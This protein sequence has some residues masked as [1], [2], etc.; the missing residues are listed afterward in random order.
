[1]SSPANSSLRPAWKGGGRGFQPPPAVERQK[2][3][4][5][6]FAALNDEYDDDEDDSAELGKQAEEAANR[7]Q[8]SRRPGRSLADLAARAPQ[9]ER[10]ASHGSER[11][12]G[13]GSGGGGGVSRF[14]SYV[15]STTAP[16]SANVIRYTRERLLSMRPPPAP[17]APGELLK[18]IEGTVILSDVAQ[19]PVCWDTFDAEAIWAT[20]SRERR[21][22][23]KSGLPEAMEGGGGV[24][25]R[26]T[27]SRREAG[28]SSG[29]WQRGVAL[30]PPDQ[31]K[32]NRE[33]KDAENPSDLW[34]DPVAT[35]AAA[36]FSAF[37]AMPQ[38]DEPFDF[39][40]MAEATRKFDEDI[41]GSRSRT[42][43][44]ANSD[45]GVSEP[46]V[47]VDPKRPLASIGTTIQSGSGD[48][49]NVFED[50]DEPGSGD[51]EEGKPAIKGGEEDAS[52]SSRLMAMIG[53]K[54][55]TAPADAASEPAARAWGGAEPGSKENASVP[56]NPWG[57]P[58]LPSQ[59]AQGGGG[60]DIQARMR[61]EEMAQNAREAEVARRQQQE[62]EEV[63]R[64][65]AA[66][67]QSRNAA[68]LQQQ[69]Q[70]Q[71]Q[72]D[73]VQSQV[74]LVLMERISTILE[75]AWGQ[76][77]LV[78]ILS[79]LH[80]GDSRVIP[81]LSNTDALRALIL[82]NPRR[83]AL[84]PN[85]VFGTEMA[86]LLLTNA[87][88]LQ[89][90]TAQE[91]AKAAA[92]AQQQEIQRREEQR[93]MQERAA[94]QK[95]SVVSGA[96]WYYSD[97]Q[98]NVQGPFRGE[99]M[100][101]WL[102]AGYFKSDLPISQQQTGPFHPLSA[103]FPDLS[104]AFV[105][106]ELAAEEAQA[107]ERLDAERAEAEERQAKEAAERERQ[108]QETAERDHQAREA[109]EL[110]RQANEA[111]TRERTAQEVARRRAMEDAAAVEANEAANESSTQL[112]MML[113]L[114]GAAANSASAAQAPKATDK[115]AS[116]SSGK[117]KAREMSQMSDTGAPQ[118]KPSAPA[119]AWGGASK[120]VTRK[121]MS[122]IQKEEARAAAIQ[123]MNREGGRSS[124]SGW[125]NVAASHGG[126]TGW[127]G[128]G[129]T[130]RPVAVLQPQSIAN[131]QQGIAKPNVVRAASA[132]AKVAAAPVQR[133]SSVSSAAEEFGA[134][135]SP[136]L[137]KWCK[138]Q[139]QRLTG[140]DDLTLVSFCMSLNDPI[141]IRQYLTT[142]LGST[143][144]VNNFATEFINRKS[145][146]N[147]QEE[148][149]TTANVKKSR[150]KKGGR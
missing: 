112:K 125:A 46:T 44:M 121:S 10:S 95:V 39:E 147:A 83:I 77:D 108:A 84:R 47:K 23:T 136:S 79:T 104:V 63:Q 65:A 66:E 5:N 58:L 126:S 21:A 142:Y 78:S 119:P 141:E 128:G 98:N 25:V 91:Q 60:F 138:E 92:Q 100:R 106:A 116:K 59:D 102:E 135:M 26:R 48:N 16:S 82:R 4:T 107:K 127:S 96:P 37:G 11:S 99:E 17:T 28:S 35:D 56:L 22:S 131:A 97:P 45:D 110:E 109:A 71:Q 13:S 139:M 31:V 40:K 115:R 9:R 80:A 101:Q 14:S 89:E 24:G 134:K 87:Q 12:A 85:P 122:E 144:Q 42:S 93:K 53:V 61:E 41:H 123:A 64:R 36:D 130:Q 117:S 140:T 90:K 18:A 19:D 129:A 113:G 15:S 33:N 111:A 145:G 81:L 103:L 67:E 118:A 146:A 105:G 150:K 132:G 73:G 30:P 114:G 72:Q 34:D 124:S 55:E 69:Q 51:K 7:L 75:N 1:M 62:R 54:K 52:A 137:E 143:S 76:S 57:G 94:Q 120:P 70:Q 2:S 38:D 3:A 29:R 68:N 20:V 27:S 8:S 88:W 6:K 149:E 133:T 148:W 74:E 50:F 32:K 43:S 86:S 49:V